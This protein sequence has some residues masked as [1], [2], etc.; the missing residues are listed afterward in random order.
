MKF[1]PALITLAAAGTVA[2]SHHRHGHAHMKRSPVATKV[3][4]VPGPTV[5]S[6]ELNGKL[7]SKEDACKGI[8][9]GTF[10]WA[11]GGEYPEACK[12]TPDAP[13]AKPK[14]GQEFYEKP[15]PEAPTTTL[16]YEPPK[17]S[18]PSVPTVSIEIPEIPKPSTPKPDGGSGLDRDFPDGEI[19]CSD[20]PSE[21][22]PLS[23]DWL[24]HGGWSGIQLPSYGG[25]LISDIRTAIDGEGCEEGCMCSY[26]CPPGYQKSQWPQVQGATGQ[27]VGGL[28]C[29]NGKLR[30]T[31]PGLSKK[32]CIKGTGGV[33]VKN[34]MDE[35]VAVCRTDYPGKIH[36]C[37]G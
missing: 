34:T 23:L 6:Y 9:D 31:N 22:G 30:L 36:S 33:N 37:H 2:A 4:T 17:I 29:K 13:V 32:L 25:G 18:L 12:P 35:V 14:A 26:A 11:D 24:G 15:K 10:V 20:F 16:A 8:M 7:I 21:Y 1:T 28:E 3:V 27:S 5:V 19:E